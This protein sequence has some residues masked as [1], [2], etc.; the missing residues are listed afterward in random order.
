VRPDGALKDIRDTI[1]VAFILPGLHRVAR[2]A[3][4]AFESI[5]SEL[6]CIAGFSVTLIGSGRERPDRPYHFIHSPCTPREKFE[7]WPRIPPFRSEYAWEEATFAARLGN[8]YDPDAYDATITC[9]YPFLNWLVRLR[10]RHRPRNVFV[11]QNGDWP[12]QA[13]NSEF[14][15]FNCDALVCT[16]PVYFQ[17]HNDGRP[18][19]LIPNAVDPKRFQDAAP[20]RSAWDLPPSGLVVLMVSALV[21][22]KRVVEG[23]RAVAPMKQI[24]LVIAGDGPLREQVDSEGQALMGSRFRRVTAPF[25][26]MPSLYRSADILL[27]MSQDEPFGNIYVEALAAGLPVVAH[28]WTS[29]RWLF[30]DEALLV[31]TNDADNVRAAL[32]QAMHRRSPDEAL[33]RVSLVMRRFTW[34]AVAQE[35]ARCLDIIVTKDRSR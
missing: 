14:R 12:V 6:G 22:S 27:H 7:H 35:Y 34:K 4:M 3:E 1:R 8:R 23:I 30:E 5:A 20:N 18:V 29:T 9:S 33:R 11:T 24:H 28:D 13:R 2:G 32:N 31:D 25:D 17:R 16:N 26:R 21:P 19:W 10:G 15:W